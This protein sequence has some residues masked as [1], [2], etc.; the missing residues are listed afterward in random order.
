MAPTSRRL[1]AEQVQGNVKGRRDGYVYKLDVNLPQTCLAHDAD[2]EQQHDA[3][4]MQS[5]PGRRLCWM[6]HTHC[7]QHAGEQPLHVAH[8]HAA[9]SPLVRHAHHTPPVS[10]AHFLYRT[11]SVLRRLP[12]GMAM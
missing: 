12:I 5:C 11:L 9:A 1:H 2:I 7:W 6:G 3:L 8:T 4:L 10:S